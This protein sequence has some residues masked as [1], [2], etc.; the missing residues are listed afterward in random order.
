MTNGPEDHKRILYGRRRGHKLRP[1]QQELVNNLLPH[2]LVSLPDEGMM[3]PADQFEIEPDTRTANDSPG[4]AFWLEVGFGGGEHL[5]AQAEANPDVSIFGC[6]PF[7]NGVASLLAHI[8]NKGLRNVRIHNDDARDLIAALPEASIDRA[9]LLFPDPWPKSRHAKRRFV[10]A[11]NLTSL[12]RV[13]TDDAEFRVATDHVSYCRWAL[14]QLLK[15]PDFS[16]QAECASDWRVRSADWPP[17][18]Y[19]Q[20]ALDQGRKPGYFKFRRKMRESN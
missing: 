17:T 12:A 9:F 5:A 1:G 4:N 14:S 16:W 18:R 2:L 8:E 15:H 13:L 6:E 3:N 11:E 10:S 19:E 7:E 20:K